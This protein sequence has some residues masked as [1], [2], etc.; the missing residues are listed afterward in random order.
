[1]LCHDESI[2]GEENS[3]HYNNQR[4]YLWTELQFFFF[5]PKLF[6][7][8]DFV[9]H[10]SCQQSTCI[11]LTFKKRFCNTLTSLLNLKLL[12]TPKEKYH[13]N[14]NNTI[15]T[16]LKWLFEENILHRINP[17][18][19]LAHVTVFGIMPS[20]VKLHFHQSSHPSTAYQ[21]FPFLFF[22]FFFGMPFM[23]FQSRKAWQ[24]WSFPRRKN[25]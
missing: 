3:Y 12:L 23:T 11:S 14:A 24:F 10:H 1:M 22:L 17:D 16:H 7:R 21:C 19:N 20:L 18:L 25:P 13:F 2:K 8:S 15:T 5:K 9:N 4:G 6:K